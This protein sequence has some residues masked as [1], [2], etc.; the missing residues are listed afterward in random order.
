MVISKS[1]NSLIEKNDIINISIILTIALAIGIYLIATTV[2]IT[3]DGVFYIGQAKG[4]SEDPMAV[5]KGHPFGYPF[6]IFLS[7]KFA[8]LF[9]SSSSAYSWIYSAQAVNLICR[10]LSLIPLYFIG[11]MLVGSRHSFCGLLILIMLPYPARFGSDVL[12]DWPHIFF[13]ACGFLAILWAAKE[14]NWW[15][16]GPIGLCAGFGYFVRSVCAQ[17]IVY[18]MI[19]LGYCFLK[20]A[21]T[22]SRSR[23]ILAIALLFSGFLILAG[24]YSKA[25]GAILP[26][27]MKGLIYSLS[28]G[29]QF[30]ENEQQ[31]PKDPQ[32]RSEYVG[33]LYSTLVDASYKIYK[34]I[35]ESLLWFFALPWLIAIIYH[36][37]PRQPSKFKLLMA[38]FIALNM[39]FLFLR[40]TNFDEAMSKRYALPLIAF[41]ICYTPKG[42]ELVISWIA[43]F[44]HQKKLI[45]SGR[46]QRW[47]YALLIFGLCI[48]FPKLLEPIR[49]E[50]QGYLAAAK[51]IKE[52]IDEKDVLAVPDKRISFY[53]EREGIVYEGGNIPPTAIYVVKI[54]KHSDE[55]LNFGE[56]AREV[57]SVWV[58]KRKKG[59]KLIIYK[60][61]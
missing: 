24:P 61:M 26:P 8:T 18:G 52:N 47:A 33:G 59:G 10:V 39:S 55:E 58:D 60:L 17:L 23:T 38:A 29:H 45:A 1:V 32:T 34:S 21:K 6:L 50:K 37:S 51:W 4:F 30:N 25:R 5:I 22:M 36:F 56:T 44:T 13:L 2:L 12:R 28:P 46:I 49:K 20:P 43:N 3:G 40:S 16:F 53:A 57:Y 27:K 14:R 31:I 54:M 35:G 41:T 15:I 42:L 48:C 19:W 11:K 7:H 9:S